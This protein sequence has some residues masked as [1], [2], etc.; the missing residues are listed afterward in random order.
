MEAAV[1]V[2]FW[3]NV[4]A[5]AAAEVLRLSRGWL[6]VDYDW[7]PH[8]TDGCGIEVEGPIVVL[9]G[10]HGRGNV[11]FAKEIQGELCLG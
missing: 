4:E 8:G 2:E 3:T 7:T 9:P 11:G 6:F 1:V 10:R 5:F